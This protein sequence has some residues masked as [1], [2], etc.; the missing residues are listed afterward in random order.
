MQSFAYPHG[1]RIVQ[2]SEREYRSRQEAGEHAYRR[3]QQR[4]E[5]R[6]HGRSWQEQEQSPEFEKIISASTRSKGASGK[7]RARSTTSTIP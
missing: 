4:E 6:E 7:A 1:R 3:S 2:T 5:E